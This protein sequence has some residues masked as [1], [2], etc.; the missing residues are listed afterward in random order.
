MPPKEREKEVKTFYV[1]IPAIDCV[2]NPDGAFKPVAAF[3]SREEAI[4]FCQEH[5][6]A[7]EK[8]RVCLVTG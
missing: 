8:G 4:K 6:G 2:G 5:F 7:D 3:S 1:D